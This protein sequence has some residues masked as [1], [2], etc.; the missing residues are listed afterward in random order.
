MN[1]HSFQHNLDL[2]HPHFQLDNT[3]WLL[4]SSSVDNIDYV[5]DPPDALN[6]VWTIKV[7]NFNI[8]DKLEILVEEH[9]TFVVSVSNKNITMIIS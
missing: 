4:L 5:L 1:K 6:A 8:L 9:Q 2:A 3:P 7:R